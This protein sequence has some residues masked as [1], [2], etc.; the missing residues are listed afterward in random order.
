MKQY[1]HD[2]TLP[3]LAESLLQTADAAIRLEDYDKASR[4]IADARQ[5][6]QQYLSQDNMIEDDGVEN[7][8]VHYNDAAREL[9]DARK[10]NAHYRETMLAMGK[11]GMAVVKASEENLAELEELKAMQKPSG[12]KIVRHG[13]IDRQ[14]KQQ[15]DGVGDASCPLYG[16]H[17]RISG[18]FEQILMTRN[19]VAAACQRLG[20]KQV[21]EG[22]AKSMDIV[23]L[24]NNAGA[25][26]MKKIRLWQG[27]GRQIETLS[28]FDI[29]KIFDEYLP[30]L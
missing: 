17:I 30:K 3:S 19:D 22:I 11:T 1:T 23:I 15:L 21:S 14:Y 4:A 9:E 5:T 12:P 10:L 25:E 8:W 29:K 13:K 6:L 18:T 2:Y 27:E 20:A 24:G 16:K 7:G 26:K 28:Q